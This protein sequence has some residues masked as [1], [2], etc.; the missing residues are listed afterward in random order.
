[1]NKGFSSSLQNMVELLSLGTI[2]LG[3]VLFFYRRS[4]RYLRYFQQEEY[5]G[6]R[7]GAWLVR[8]RAFDRKGSI[9]VLAAGLATMLS[10]PTTGTLLSLL[11]L[12]ALVWIA[13]REEDPRKVGK[14]RLNMTER[15]TRIHQAALILYTA[16][17]LTVASGT[18]PAAGSPSVAW[19]WL[20]QVIFFQTCGGWL[21]LGNWLLLPGEKTRQ[22][23]FME[24]A[25]ATLRLVNPFVVGITGS[26]GKTTTK[27]I[28]GE[29]LQGL[30]PTFWPP[31][32]INTP[33]G[34]TREIRERLMPE[35]RFAV[36]EMGAYQ[37]GSIRRLCSLVP[38]KA[39]IITAV[40]LMHLERFGSRENIYLAKAEL[41]QAIPENGI[42]VCNGDNEGARRIAREYPKRATLL[43]GLEPDRGRLDCWMSDVHTSPDGTSFI[44]HW[45]GK[46]Y[47]GSTRLLGVP[48]LLNIL[49]AFTMACA[50]GT[51]PE[52]VLAIIRNSEPQKNRLQLVRE[53]HTM[54]L[55]DAYNSNPIGFT[56]A[57]DVLA[58]LPGQRKI[59]VTPGMVELG[60]RQEEENRA[61]GRRAAAVC[62]LVLLVGNTNREALLQG[63]RE[64]GLSEDQVLMFDHRDRALSHLGEIRCA[65]D[66]VLLENDLPDLYEGALR[67]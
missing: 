34:I 48:M 13:Y 1:M 4:L 6:A 12:V 11:G 47:R 52:Y 28:L 23:R 22:A 49:A 29:A 26:Y 3:S 31:K 64:G 57:L 9:V 2:A 50:L 53:D 30:G 65:G 45:N 10:G 19:F 58:A 66:I 67:F 44:I 60:P 33:M 38:P 17:L 41:A 16:G 25:K 21:V 37:R 63:L 56:A 42:L 46:D 18:L 51:D 62:D 5:D 8:N 36:I 27:A 24:E 39:G 55:N 35:H 15:A 20:L 7:F 14:I 40:G 54:V 43:Y 32:S 59:L 61:V